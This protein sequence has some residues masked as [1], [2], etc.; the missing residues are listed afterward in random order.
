M[1]LRLLT[2][3]TLLTS[4]LLT[5]CQTAVTPIAISTPATTA[6]LVP[7]RIPPTNTVT[8]EPTVTPSATPLPVLPLKA[9]TPVPELANAISAANATS[10]VQIARWTTTNFEN[11]NSIAFSPDD[12]LLASGSDDGF[13]RIWDLASGNFIAELSE[14]TASQ[15]LSIAFSPDGQQLASGDHGTLNVSNTIKL[16]EVASGEELFSLSLPTYGMVADPDAVWS[17][18]FS[19]DGKLLASGSYSGVIKLWNAANGEE[20]MTLSEGSPDK[21]TAYSG[22][23][24]IGSV[25]FSPDGKLL[26]SSSNDGTITLWEVASGKAVRTMNVPQAW[27]VVFSP[28]GQMLASTAFYNSEI[29]LWDVA[30]G[31]ALGTLSGHDWDG[32]LAFSPDGTVLAAGGSKTAS[33]GTFARLPNDGAIILWEVAS[34]KELFTLWSERDSY[35]LGTVFSHN[36]KFI[37]SSSSEGAIY[38]WGIYP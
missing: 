30:S 3:V 28:D 11:V 37:A 5:A 21:D 17:V 26:A 38:L 19:P 10:I 29:K 15:V 25:V 24:R 18:N 6:T 32:S 35:V 33:D 23:G 2:Q 20:V 31:K 4:I 36:G 22:Q 7:T 13:V 1:T 12:A 14:V 34:G 8:P 9:G 27:R 16:W